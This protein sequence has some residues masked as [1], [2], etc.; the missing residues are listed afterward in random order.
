ML[1][2]LDDDDDDDDEVCVLWLDPS[3]YDMYSVGHTFYFTKY[4]KYVL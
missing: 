3:Q 4:Q 1:S 2:A